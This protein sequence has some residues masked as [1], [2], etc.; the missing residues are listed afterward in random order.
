MD[1]VAALPARRDMS[2][3]ARLG[4]C[5]GL[6]LFVVL[7][8]AD[9]RGHAFLAF[10]DDH[11][12]TANPLVRDGLSLDAARRA[13]TGFHA[14]NWHPLTWLS[15]MADVSLFGLEPKGH[16][17]VNL[18][19]HAA[20]A[21]L[22]F[23]ALAALTGAP[24]RAACA[25]A[26]FAVHP[27]RVESVAWVAERKDLLS[28]CFALLAL[29]AWARFA[30]SGSRAAYS[31]ALA[32]FAA[33]LLAKPMLVTWPFVLALTELW[34][35]GRLRTRADLLGR[36]RELAPFVA[37]S[38][39]SCAV[40]LAAQTPA[41]T[42]LPLDLRLANAL[43]AFPAYLARVFWPTDLAALYPYRL[44]PPAL[45]VAAA[46]A[47]VVALTALAVVE[48]RRRPWLLVGWLWFAGML[49]PTLGLVQVGVQAFADRYTYLPMLG[50]ALALVWTVADAALRS[51]PLRVAALTALALALGALGVATR[52]QVG[53][54][55]DTVSLFEHALA[56]TRDNG[57]AHRELGVALAARGELERARG[58][59][60]AALDIDRHDAR[61]RA[62]LGLVLARLGDPERGFELVREAVQQEPGLPAGPLLL[63]AALERGGRLAEA[64]AAYREALARDPHEPIAALQLARLLAIAPEPALRDGAEAVRL[65][66]RAC[67]GDACRD[68]AML[69]VLGLAYMEAGRQEDAL[70]TVARALEAAE[71]RGDGVWISRLSQRRAAYERG[72]PV[73]VRLPD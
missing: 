29:L 58:E 47:L 23:V 11:Y 3:G 39:A 69:D 48:R 50:L 49:V 28:G 71:A 60:A 55:R 41:M 52:A 73:R 24:W 37:L 14:G 40:T 20:N 18:A 22:A 5:A 59:L 33:G 56:V 6:A 30:R 65:A 10:D 51:R 15:H 43:L 1:R 70:R 19:L 64:Q 4:V 12:V 26:L 2:P 46:G 62:Q 66:E 63:G 8:F 35:L 54:W 61:A 16:H 17:L 67:A 21:V 27:L 57:F 68:P 42:P 38:A 44:D 25:A 31:G 45:A 7:V 53:V 34:P 32:A 72:E 9:V 36:A 13:F